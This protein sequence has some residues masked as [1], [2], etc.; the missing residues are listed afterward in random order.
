LRQISNSLT[1]VLIAV[2]AISF[3]ISD[4]IEGGVIAFVILLNIVIGFVQDLK[5]EK[6]IQALYAL[7]APTCKVTRQGTVSLIKAEELVTGDIV[8][9]NVGDIVPADLRLISGLNLTADEALLT[10]ESLPISKHPDAVL[11]KPDMPLGDR[12]NSEQPRK[13]SLFLSRLAF[14]PPLLPPLIRPHSPLYLPISESWGFERAAL[15]PRACIPA[16]YSLTGH[17]IG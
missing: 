10:G 6:T 9:L 4:F 3:A 8:M 17:I 16:Y 13:M 5:A 11:A 14:G 1:I 7:S 12:V 15:L 2:M